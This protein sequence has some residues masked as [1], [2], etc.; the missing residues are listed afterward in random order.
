MV[1]DMQAAMALAHP[2]VV[3]VAPLLGLTRRQQVMLGMAVLAS[4]LQ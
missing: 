3:V 2:V 1:K 4:H